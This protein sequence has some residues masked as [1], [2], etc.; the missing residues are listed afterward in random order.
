MANQSIYLFYGTEN[1]LIEQA[2]TSIINKRLSNDEKDMNFFTYDLL[3]EPLENVVEE[4]ETLPF[5][6]GHKVVLAKNALLFTGQKLKIE[7]DLAGLEHLIQSPPDYSTIIFWVPYE[8]LDERK[9][10]VKRLKEQGTIKSFNTLKGEELLGWIQNKGKEEKVSIAEEAA[11]LLV[12][13]SGPDLKLLAQEIKK[14]AIF[15][16]ENGKI[17][18]AVVEELGARTMEQNVFA[19]SEHLA[20]LQYEQAFTVLYDL[21]LNKEEPV[22]IIALLA[23]QFRIMMLAKEMYQKGYSHQQ[24]GSQIGAHPYA[25]KIALQQSTAFSD[26]Q[27]KKIIKQLAEI[28]YEIKTGRKEKVLALEMF[29]FYLKNLMQSH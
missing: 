6:A 4:A 22:K 26:P 20:N 7:H 3:N 25:I 11:E 27:L 16:G 15:V 9:K 13:T 18:K 5:I 29:I 21:L 19:L 2:V 24:I 1:Y 17:T 10:I 12:N 14:M 23:R 8:K 28:D